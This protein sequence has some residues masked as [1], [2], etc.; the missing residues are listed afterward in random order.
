VMEVGERWS[1]MVVAVDILLCDLCHDNDGGTV[2]DG[3]K[4]D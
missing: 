1:G 2:S 4:H 3:R